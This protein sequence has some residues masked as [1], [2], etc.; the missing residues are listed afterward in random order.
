MTDAEKALAIIKAFHDMAH[1]SEKNEGLTI[2]KDW[3]ENT[4]T[5]YYK[6]NHMHFGQMDSENEEG[7]S[8][9]IDQMYNQFCKNK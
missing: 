7:F 9:L 4:L 2:C 5:I 8:I 1:D 3:D 6:N